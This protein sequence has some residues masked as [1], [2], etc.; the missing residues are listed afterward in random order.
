MTRYGNRAVQPA[1]K[2]YADYEEI[3]P[4]RDLADRAVAAASPKELERTMAKAEA[5]LAELRRDFPVWMAS[6][7]KDLE[8]MFVLYKAGAEDSEILLFRKAHDM[9]GQAATFGY[10]LAGRAA[11]C[12]CRLMDALKR[13]P[14]DVVEAHMMAIRVIVRENVNV[15]DHRIGLEMI[16]GLE[17]LGHGL[18]Q[19]ALKAQ[20]G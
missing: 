15:D 8:Q 18:I 13:V 19:K 11:D 2:T 10:P 4:I 9:R 7:L 14:D 16:K 1:S 5:G 17:H 6:E 12:L 20:G 3:E